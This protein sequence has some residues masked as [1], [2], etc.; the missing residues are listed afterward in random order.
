MTATYR[1]QIHKDFTFADLLQAVGRLHDLGITHLYLS[2]ILES[3]PGSV[4]GYDGTDFAAISAER[5][6][7]AGFR[8]L[9]DK[10]RALTPPMKVILDIVP[11]H[12]AADTHNPYWNDVLKNGPASPFWTFFDLRVPPNKKIQIP[13]LGD[14][15]ENV[16]KKGELKLKNGA[17]HYYDIV[18][19]LA[20]GSEHETDIRKALGKQHYEPVFW[21]TARDRI[22]YRRFFDIT[23]LIALRVE[24]DAV[25]DRVHARL[26]DL[27]AREPLIDTLRV[28]HIDGLS[29]PAGYLGWL[30]QKAPHVL[31]E[32]ILSGD[33][34]LRRDWKID[35]T[36]GY[37]FINRLNLLMTDKAGFDTLE[38]HWRAHIQP[39]WKDFH[40]AVVQGKQDA[41]RLLFSAELKRLVELTTGPGG[42]P[43]EAELFWT[44]LTVGLPVYRTYAYS[45]APDAE[46]RRR[47]MQACRKAESIYGQPFEQAAAKYLD[48]VLNPRA[49]RQ[50][51]ALR[52]WQQ[53]SG[54]V[55]AKGLEDTA[56]YRY[57]PLAA[58]NEVGCEPVF[59][60][61]EDF[62]AWATQ[63]GAC[64]PRT[65]NATSTHDTKRSEDVRA[66]LYGLSAMP[67]AWT[68]FADKAAAMNASFNP[69]D[70]PTEYLFYQSLLGIW[71]LDGTP[72]DAL[73]AR[74]KTYMLKAVKEA[75][76]ATSWLD[77]DPAYEGRLEQF[78]SAAMAH[79]PFL[80]LAG[81]FMERLSPLGALNGLTSVAM[82]ILTPGIPDFYQGMERW[83]FSLVDPDNRRPVIYKDVPRTKAPV[84]LLGHWRDGEIKHWLTHRL[85][86]IRRE[87]N[88]LR[89]RFTLSAL[90]VAGRDAQSVVAFMAEKGDERLIVVLP[91][92]NMAASDTLRL[93][94]LDI[95]IQLPDLTQTHD[96]LAQEAVSLAD[97]RAPAAR[98][99]DFPLLI[100]AAKAPRP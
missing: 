95:E 27:L 66:R 18:L 91:R 98:L 80:K 9:C 14:T 44:G 6:G 54:P 11:N 78:I 61:R 85:L 24:D 22:D 49:D 17:L 39:A 5:G 31:V 56:H 13:V 86:Q 70:K 15:L 36:T 41:L 48:T 46:D 75:K 51:Q 38:N 52:E 69:P 53:L 73:A 10:I 59:D 83:D 45:S 76:T 62:Y 77:P 40:A 12:M 65:L 8:A 47:I 37:E 23:G 100:A 92:N 89:E 43:S 99:Q 72:D 93:P 35:G 58:L 57:M 50:F 82:K 32:K 34:A 94:A 29:D 60:A 88:W 55:M 71:P 7:D 16:L 4:H 84:S 19:P 2:P 1:L 63:R 68:D 97:L 87:R 25:R 20:P 64:W 3:V 79:P 26:F 42:N 74:L 28:D 33:E 21:R 96:L 30:S 81:D 90:P 67:D